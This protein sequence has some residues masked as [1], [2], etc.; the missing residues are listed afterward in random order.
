MYIGGQKEQ[1]IE[2]RQGITSGSAMQVFTHGPYSETSN[3]LLSGKFWCDQLC[4]IA[5]V[6]ES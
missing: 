4:W 3:S 6:F 2:P 5:K 1:R